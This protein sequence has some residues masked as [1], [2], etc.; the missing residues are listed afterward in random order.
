MNMKRQVSVSVFLAILVIILA[1]LYIK[2]NNE[3]KPKET[4]IT[5]ENDV[6]NEE[7]I[8]ISQE[9]ITCPYYIKDADGRLIVFESKNQS[10]FMETSIETKS[11]PVEI[12]EKLEAGIFFQSE[13][14]LYDFLESYSS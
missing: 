12:R 6:S 7:S 1:W 10:V 4:T 9:Y 8:T 2:F 5:T 11:L 14:D 13:G 3:T